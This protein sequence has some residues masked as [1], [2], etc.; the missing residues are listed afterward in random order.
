MIRKEEKKKTNLLHKYFQFIIYIYI[1]YVIRVLV[2]LY[3]K[4]KMRKSDFVLVSVFVK[5]AI[6]NAS[7]SSGK[8]ASAPS[9]YIN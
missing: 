7:L 4:K 9:S 3:N 6:D 8:T 2:V 1:F 5:Y